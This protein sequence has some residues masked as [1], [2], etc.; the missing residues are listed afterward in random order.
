MQ[1]RQTKKQTSIPP[2]V[3]QRTDLER[4][5]VFGD[6]L[7]E[8]PNEL[9]R[10]IHLK[11]LEL[12]LSSLQK[13]ERWIWEFPSLEILKIKKT[14]LTDLPALTQTSPIKIL[15]LSHNRLKSWPGSMTYLQNLESLEAAHN[16]LKELPQGIERLP[17]LKR[18]NLDG[19]QL[20]NIHPAIAECEKLSHLSLDD[21][22][23][24]EEAQQ[25]LFECFKIWR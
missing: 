15:S 1:I 24:T 10:L 13:L 6:G 16:E 20:K 5:E 22:P 9:Q 23:L 18:L 21:N 2:E 14:P 7:T 4:L 25:F 11:S 12:H 17:R 19:N 3:L 8:L